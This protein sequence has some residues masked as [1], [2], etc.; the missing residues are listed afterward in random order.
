LSTGIGY[1]H[2]D[3]EGF[4]GLFPGKQAKNGQVQQ[5]FVY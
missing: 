3:K 1:T 5:A 4:F 2:F